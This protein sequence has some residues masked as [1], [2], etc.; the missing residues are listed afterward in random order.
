M[1]VPDIAG[2]RL[3]KNPTRTISPTCIRRSTRHEAFVEATAAISASTRPACRPAR[4]TSTSRSSSARSRPAIRG[5]RQRPSSIQNIMGGICARVCP[6]ETLCEEACVRNLAEDKPV[7]IGHAAA[8]RDRSSD[9]ARRAS[10]QRAP[11]RPESASPSSAPGRRALPARIASRCTATT[12]RSSTRGKSRAASTN[13]ASPPTRRS[14]I[15]RSARSTSS[16]RSAASRSRTARRSAAISR[17][18]T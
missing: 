2:R 16:S 3:P 13:T 8:L 11:R 12:S 1:A 10:V 6:V 9:G 4:R 15:S 18:P 7:K 5:A 17:S 14:T